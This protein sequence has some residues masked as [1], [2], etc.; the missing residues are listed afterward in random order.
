MPSQRVE[1][2][3]NKN[4]TLTNVNTIKQNHIKIIMIIIIPIKMQTIFKN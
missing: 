1:N 2:Q 3:I 4:K